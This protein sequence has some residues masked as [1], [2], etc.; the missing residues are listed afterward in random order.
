M[1]AT[2]Q[3]FAL[4]P[5]VQFHDNQVSL[6]NPDVSREIYQE[7]FANEQSFNLIEGFYKNDEHFFCTADPQNGFRC[8]VYFTGKGIGE[9]S[10]FYFDG[11][12]G[13][14]SLLEFLKTQPISASS[15]I[16]LEA[17][18][19]VVQFKGKMAERIMQKKLWA[20]KAKTMNTQK[21]PMSYKQGKHLGCAKLLVG[22]KKA[23]SCLL[24]IPLNPLY[25]FNRSAPRDPELQTI[26][27]E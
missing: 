23:Y 24:S 9:L 3:V 25:N 15:Y 12:F 2:C 13:K 4:Q 18:R 27:N 8:H 10:S 11:D 1:S 17:D 5:Q 21:G 16:S 20:L 22:N 6:T 14:G 7:I 26:R 19:V